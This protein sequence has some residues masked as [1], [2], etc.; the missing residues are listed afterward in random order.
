MVTGDRCWH[1][2]TLLALLF[3]FTVA[4]AGAQAPEDA[5]TWAPRTGDAWVDATLADINAYATRY[6]DAF[7][8]ELAR[9]QSAPRALVEETLSADATPGD[10]YF[11]CAMAQA[12]GR[13][14]RELL[15]AWREDAGEGW[16]GVARR[17]DPTLA[18]PALQRVRRGLVDSYARWARPPVPETPSRRGQT[19]PATR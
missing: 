6:P 2:L 15:Q 5:A 3:A 11:A 18:G 12:L 1:R 7:V 14:C 16:G 4:P 9:Y 19:R 13:P 8:D 10:V 17:V